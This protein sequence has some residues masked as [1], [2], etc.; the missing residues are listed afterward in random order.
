MEEGRNE[1]RT[2]GERDDMEGRKRKKENGGEK[3]Q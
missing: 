3:I 2:D 1:G